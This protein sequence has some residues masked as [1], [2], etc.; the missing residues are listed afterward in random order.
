MAFKC[1]IQQETT[2]TTSRY[3]DDINSVGIFN[4]LCEV[5]EKF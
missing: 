4:V 5:C 1:E 3:K 2:P